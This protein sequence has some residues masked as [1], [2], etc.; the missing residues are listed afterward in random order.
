MGNI[1]GLSVVV[2]A[3]DI[4]CVFAFESERDAVLI[5]HPDAE[6]ARSVALKGLEPVAG[7]HAQGI[8]A[9]CGVHKIQLATNH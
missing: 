1:S 9:R 4:V 3:L 7:R 8:H 5:V 2:L 6:R